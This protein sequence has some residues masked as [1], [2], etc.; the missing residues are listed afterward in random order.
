MTQNDPMPP[1]PGALQDSWDR[2]RRHGLAECSP[3][4]D[5]ALAPADLTARLQENN[6][7]LALSRPVI[8]GLYRQIGRTSSTVLLA[9]RKGLIL[10][11]VGHMDFMERSQAVAL[12]PG[13]DWSEAAM[14][15]NAIGTALQTGDCVSVRGDEHYL[16]RNRILACVATPILTPS[17]G[18]LGVL[19][20][21]SDARADLAHTRALL[22]TTAE[23][24]EERLLEHL[25]QGFLT[26]HFSL[27]AGALAMPLHGLTVFDE[28]GQLLACNRTARSLLR[29]AESAPQTRCENCFATSWSSLISRAALDPEAV[30][31]LQGA[32]GRRFV[33]RAILRTRRRAPAAQPGTPGGTASGAAAATRGDNRAT[34]QRREESRLGAL[35]LGDPQM[36]RVVE[37]LRDCAP[38]QT[39]LLVEGPMGS[40]KAF[41]IRAFH[42]DHRASLDA[43]LIGLDCTAL[44]FGSA[45]AEAID[46]AWTQAANGILALVEFDLLERDLQERLCEPHDGSRARIVGITRRTVAELE[47]EGF[48]SLHNFRNNGGRILTMPALSTRTD[49]DALVRHF[50]REA[51]PD[52]PIYV[53]ADTIDL[54]RR[55]TWPGNIR[56]LRNQLR[57]MLALAGDDARELCPADIPAELFDEGAD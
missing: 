50:V 42:A 44:P 4:D 34:A 23:L 52:R 3:L 7:L 39:P 45:G 57:L 9:D 6:R 53:S 13:V 51:A 21:S 28:A 10:S 17:G 33:A 2:S 46:E 14:G 24:I 37:S 11:T 55:H 27:Q 26:V 32:G 41:L 12:R 40:G 18:M 47:S 38:E 20:V 48:L 22:R 16:E 1:E 25:D 19:D 29:L 31:A 54:L 43:P 15:T 56:E 35:R 8:E 36:E 30:F 49:F 5:T